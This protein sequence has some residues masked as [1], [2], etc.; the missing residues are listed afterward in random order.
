MHIVSGICK[1]E[2]RSDPSA[3]AAWVE[4]RVLWEG[5]VFITHPYLG[6]L[7]PPQQLPH[8]LEIRAGKQAGFGSRKHPNGR[9]A[10][11]LRLTLGSHWEATA[12]VEGS[13]FLTRASIWA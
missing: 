6:A 8:C 13:C 12:G 7:A 4:Q 10:A 3:A 9:E 1:R 11:P 2:L 5:G